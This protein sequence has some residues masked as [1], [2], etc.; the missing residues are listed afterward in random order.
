L[1]AEVDASKLDI[2]HAN[3][4]KSEINKIST[5]KEDE[6]SLVH[7]TLLTV[8]PLYKAVMVSLLE[9]IN[10]LPPSAGIAGIYVQID[11]NI[12]VFHAPANVSINSVVRPAIEITDELQE[13]LNTPLSGKAINAIRTFSGKGTLIW[14]ARTLD[15]NSL[16]WRYIPIRR[17]VIFIEQ[18]IKYG[19][20]SYVFSPNTAATWI[21]VKAVISNFLDSFWK[22]GGLAGAT[23]NE[24]F[25]VAIGL[26][27]TMTHE[28]VLNG[29][30]RIII[31][32]ALT[33][34][35]E[36]MVISMEQQM[37]QS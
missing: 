17:T 3:A 15:G 20:A 22:Q 7:K 30:M 33:R 25:Y 36:F 28:D 6:I 19:I 21:D 34:P 2:K 13:D 27:E 14:G 8:S 12:G 18:S 4:L 10:L 11:N 29:K 32:V 5:A 23:P 16:E 1:I 35:A 24:A 26:G 37:Q 9:Q 31:N